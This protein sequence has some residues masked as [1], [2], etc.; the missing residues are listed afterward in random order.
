M[1]QINAIKRFAKNPQVASK[2]IGN[3]GGPA[4]FAQIIGMEQRWAC[5][6]VTNWRNTGFP[7][8]AFLEFPA[9]LPLCEATAR[10][11]KE[12]A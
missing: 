7:Q 4:L 6:R 11:E 1:N 5:Q 8:G 10:T 3:A 2:V 9:I 12:A